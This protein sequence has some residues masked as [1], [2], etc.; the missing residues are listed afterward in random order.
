VHPP[1]L[2]EVPPDQ[3]AHHPYGDPIVWASFMLIGRL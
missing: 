3:E 2:P 1:A